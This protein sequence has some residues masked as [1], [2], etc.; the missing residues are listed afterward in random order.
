MESIP[1]PVGA[2]TQR[3][4]NSPCRIPAAAAMP[5]QCQCHDP[6]C[7]VPATRRNAHVNE[8]ASRAADG[9]LGRQNSLSLPRGR[10]RPYIQ[11][12]RNRLGP[13]GRR[14]PPAPHQHQTVPLDPSRPDLNGNAPITRGRRQ[15]DPQPGKPRTSLFRTI[16]PSTAPADL[17]LT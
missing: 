12:P 4:C 17:S 5:C 14:R 16:I 15:A 13:G 1:W 2:R 6:T 10:A 9:G 7:Q 11:P 3:A 8:T